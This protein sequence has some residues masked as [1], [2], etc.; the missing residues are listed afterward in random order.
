[1]LEEFPGNESGT[2]RQEPDFESQEMVRST[3]QQ[4]ERM[5]LLSETN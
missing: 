5:L 2:T 1:M 4:E 3:V